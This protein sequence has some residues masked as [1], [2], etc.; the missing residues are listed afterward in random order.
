MMEQPYQPNGTPAV[1]SALPGSAGSG[2]MSRSTQVNNQ[3]R[4]RYG[5]CFPDGVRIE[6]FD[7]AYDEG[8]ARALHKIYAEG[9]PVD[10]PG[11]P[12]KSPRV[13]RGF[14]DQGWTAEPHETWLASAGGKAVG[15]YILELPDRENLDRA[16]VMVMVSLARR[17]AGFGTGLLRH[18]AARARV[19]GRAMLT[20]FTR[21]GSPGDGFARAVGAAEDLAEI[22][23]TLD[24]G[25]IP[26]GRLAELRASTKAAAAGYAIV[27][28]A[29]PAPDEYLDQVARLNEAMGDAPRGPGEEEQ[30]WDAARVRAVGER[31]VTQGLRHYSVAACDEVTGELAGLT[32]LSVDQADPVWGHQELTVVT[33]AH[34]GHR[35]GLLLKVAMLELLAEREAE[36]RWIITGNA[37]SN[38]HMI[39]INDALAYRVFSQWTFWHLPADAVV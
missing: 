35:L 26:P 12:P 7:P 2:P 1:L 18:A 37:A 32:E 8:A 17:R 30:S 3:V 31:A 10:D 9:A 33:R 4:A 16:S 21:D 27:D 34:R 24:V 5:G 6:R 22:T 25:E 15:G 29:G 11:L 19:Q 38:T 14:L 23:R 13:F 20:G 36:L 39:A 28:W